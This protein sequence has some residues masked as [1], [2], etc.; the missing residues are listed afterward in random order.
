MTE[1]VP[2]WLEKLESRQIKKKLAHEI[3]KFIEEFFCEILR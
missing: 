2:E 1:H 3:G